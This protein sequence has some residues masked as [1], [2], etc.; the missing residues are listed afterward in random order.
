MHIAEHSSNLQLIAIPKE[1]MSKNSENTS[2]NS[3]EIYRAISTA[4]LDDI[5]ACGGFRICSSGC[6]MEVKWFAMKLSN[7]VEWGKRFYFDR[8]EQMFYVVTASIPS[9]LVKEMFYDENLDNIGYAICVGENFLDWIEPLQ[10][11]QIKRR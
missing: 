6:S 2:Q 3:I 8:G 1:K 10:T 5:K 4:E 7:A 9:E 11:L